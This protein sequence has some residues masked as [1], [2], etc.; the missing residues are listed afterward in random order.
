VRLE[1]AVVMSAANET[2][3]SWPTWYSSYTYI[4]C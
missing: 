4:Q 2:S 1:V 3:P